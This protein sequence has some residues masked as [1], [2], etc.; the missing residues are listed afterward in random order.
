MGIGFMHTEGTQNSLLMYI[1]ENGEELG[2]SQITNDQIGPNFEKNIAADAVCISNSLFISSIW[3]E[4]DGAPDAFGDVILDTAGNVYD[5]EFRENTRGLPR[6]IVTF[7]DKY[8]TTCSYL[9]SEYNRDVYLYK[10]NDSLDWDS[11]YSI[12][13]TYDSLCPY[14]IQSETIDVT[15]CLVFTDVSE[16]PGP[17]EYFA[18]L[19]SIPVKVYPNPSNTGSITLQYSNTERHENMQL[20]CFNIH[21]EEVHSERINRHQ[22]ESLID[23]RDWPNGMYLA[24]VYSENRPVGK[25]KFIVR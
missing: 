1:N 7:N 23:V 10:I 14:D 13:F 15:N 17:D 3:L 11:T 21:G 12:P 4:Q 9:F 8:L 18:N 5:I 20:R 2:Y 16:T 22:G 24:I 19:N 6:T 25:T